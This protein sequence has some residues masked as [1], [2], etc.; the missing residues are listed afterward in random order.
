[1]HLSWSDLDKP[2]MSKKQS[3]L[4]IASNLLPK[5]G[6]FAL[7]VRSRWLSLKCYG[8]V[9]HWSH[10]KG[11][12]KNSES[13]KWLKR[14]DHDFWPLLHKD[15]IEH[16]KGQV[17]WWSTRKVHRGFD[18]PSP[19]SYFRNWGALR[20]KAKEEAEQKATKE[21]LEFDLWENVRYRKLRQMEALRP[22]DLLGSHL[23]GQRE[24]QLATLLCMT[25]LCISKYVSIPQNYDV[26]R[27]IWNWFKTTIK[28][29]KNLAM[30]I[31]KSE[32]HLL[33]GVAVTAVLGGLAVWVPFACLL[34][35]QRF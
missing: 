28:W 31:E 34:K 11:K 4:E 35:R 26:F 19:S 22:K 10:L 32:H 30:E 7:S 27:A 17:A 16:V 15:K 3:K 29:R 1:M 24:E 20:L 21:G 9:N 13:W 6:L 25:Q 8:V 2:G 33:W 12:V 18:S 23:R 5:K 14:N